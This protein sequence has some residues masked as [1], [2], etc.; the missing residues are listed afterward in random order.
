MAG[1]LGRR[2]LIVNAD[3]FGMSAGVNRGIIEAHCRGIVTSTSL[4]VRWGAATEAVR[5][6]R[7]C[8]Q[9]GMGLHIDLGEWKFQDGNWMT[10]YEVVSLQNRDEV[11][12]EVTRQLDRFRELTGQ[13]P[14][15]LDSHQHV[16]REEPVR[17]V[18]IEISKQTSIPL[19]HF[20]PGISYCGEFYGQAANGVPYPEA[21]S[22]SALIRVLA[23]LSPGVTELCCHPGLDDNLETMYCRERFDEVQTLSDETVCSAI[24]DLGIELC[25]FH[26]LACTQPAG[27]LA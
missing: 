16:H 4:M 9:L 14:T 8:P 13:N 26:D 20:S 11:S 15:H 22:P 10:L 5:L 24:Q 19:R 6:S 18:M 3:D 21:I 1:Q 17:S 23:K 27:D 25:N 2:S 7:D 12:R